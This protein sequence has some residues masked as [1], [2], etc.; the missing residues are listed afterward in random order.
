MKYNPT[1]KEIKPLERKHIKK[2]EWSMTRP[3]VKS[4]SKWLVKEIFTMVSYQGNLALQI[5]AQCHRIH[6]YLDHSLGIYMKTVN[7]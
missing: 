3:G 6:T 4:I 7:R 2:E 1:S 5:D